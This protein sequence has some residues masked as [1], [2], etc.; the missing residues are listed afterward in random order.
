MK[1]LYKI[2]FILISATSFSQVGINTEEPTR[3]LDVNGNL[4]LQKTEY[5]A[6]DNTYDKVLVINSEGNVDSWKKADVIAKMDELIVETKKLYFSSS[7]DPD[8]QVPCG[9]FLLRFAD[10]SRNPIPQ[11]K[12]KTA[13]TTVTP[14]YYNIIGKENSSS[15]TFSGSIATNKTL[16]IPVDNSF[17][18]IDSTYKTNKLDEIYLSYPNDDNLYRVTYLARTMSATEYSY[19]MICEKF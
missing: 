14:V 13:N 8:I 11:I 5:K 1:N 15:N 17:V 16:S 2:L 4:R 6:N 18:S 12:L 10:G 3:M 19:T 9:K 7:P